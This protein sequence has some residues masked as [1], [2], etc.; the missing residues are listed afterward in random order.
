MKNKQNIAFTL[1]ELLVVI[2]ILAIISVVAYQNFGWA[3]NKALAWRK[4]WDIASIE[5]ALTQYKIDNNFYP[6]AWEFNSSTNKWWYNSWAVSTASNPIIVNY[7]WSSIESINSTNGWWRIMSWSIQIWAKWT[8]WK[9]ELWKYLSKDLYDPELWDI[10]VGSSWTMIDQWIWRYVYSVYRN[11]FNWPNN[12]PWTYYNIA[13]TIKEESS[14]VYS[15]S[16]VWN[17]D[18]SNF[19]NPNQYPETLIW[20]WIGNILL[21]NSIQN[22]TSSLSNY[23]VPY[24]ITDFAQ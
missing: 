10:K 11:S 12:Q 9:E 20:A 18:N 23:W 8:I 16:I 22:N 6:P 2:T 14:E 7:N 19:D 1:V 17:Y 24:A 15:T 4:I 21:N 5:N 13:Y 3:V